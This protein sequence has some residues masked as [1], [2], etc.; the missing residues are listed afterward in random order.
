MALLLE[1]PPLTTYSMPIRAGS[2]T[3]WDGGFEQP[4]LCPC[5]TEM[6]PAGTQCFF[7]TAEDKLTIW[8]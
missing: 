4:Q 6:R 2:K 1:K 7:I 5:D 3:V 8:P